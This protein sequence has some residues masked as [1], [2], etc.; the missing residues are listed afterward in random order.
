MSAFRSIL[1][2]QASQTGGIYYAYTDSNN[3]TIYSKDSLASASF[4]LQ[5][6]TNNNCVDLGNGVYRGGSG[7]YLTMTSTPA[8]ASANSWEFKTKVRYIPTSGYSC[9]FGCSGSDAQ[10]PIFGHVI[11]DRLYALL[12]SNGTSWDLFSTEIVDIDT[13]TTLTLVNDTTYY[14]K[15]GFTGSEYY[16]WYSTAGWNDTGITLTYLRTATKVF[17]ADPLM[18][19]NNNVGTSG[20]YWGGDIDLSET[21][22]IIDNT[23]ITFGSFIGN[24]LYNSSLQALTT[25]Y[26][27]GTGI[28]ATNME[29]GAL[30]VPTT[31]YT[32]SME[33]Q[34]HFKT[35]T[36]WSN[37]QL[38]GGADDVT[39]NS[40]YFQNYDSILV[41]WA[42]SNGTTPDILSDFYVAYGMYNL[43]EYW[44]KTTW[45]GTK[46][47]FYL[48]TDGTNFTNTSSQNS[49]SPVFWNNNPLYL[50]NKADKSITQCYKQY[51]LDGTYIKCDGVTVFDGATTLK[52]NLNS[53]GCTLSGERKSDVI[54]NSTVYYR[55]PSKDISNK[56]Y[57][58]KDSSNNIIY[59][60]GELANQG[61][62]TLQNASITG[63]LTNNAG[64]YSGF[65]QGSY[66]NINTSQPQTSL[67]LIVRAS[68]GI[69][70][71]VFDLLKTQ[72][73]MKG[74][75]LRT[76]QNYVSNPTYTNCYLSSDGTS[77]DTLV[78]FDCGYD[79][80]TDDNFHY[81]RI[82]WNSTSGAY[83]FSTSEDGTNWTARF[84]SEGG[85]PAP[86]WSG[87]NQTIGGNTDYIEAWTHGVVDMA[88]TSLTIDGVKTTY[89]TLTGASKLYDSNLSPLSKRFYLD[90]G[91][92]VIG[93]T[94]YTRSSADDR[95]V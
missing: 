3:N 73:D 7:K 36:N 83:S 28:I 25:N 80:P 70:S 90:N 33:M 27:N 49:S 1:I 50:G 12:S 26:K 72:P 93:D 54:I 74:I 91:N 87:N 51:Y 66:I 62:F 92:I 6:V 39:H 8:I 94:T 31:P 59:T 41:S 58:Y 11:N 22:L 42:S 48:S 4:I 55:N 40:L 53:D 44:L 69:Y 81:F 64:F 21:S 38:T 34:V 67:D 60:K 15:F 57:A 23:T 5:N 29:N 76:S 52:S 18:L 30:I 88:S 61:T 82:Q 75:L 86:Y 68:K 65:V 84:S 47:D 2:S 85:K 43:T 63:N 79:F 46:Y 14:F 37:L 17:C 89:G 24:Q 78:G 32:T 77:W 35:N 71:G 56:Y 19:L 20:Y 45:D 9:I 10:T 13:S 16:L 95:Q